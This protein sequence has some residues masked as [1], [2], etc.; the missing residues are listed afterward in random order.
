MGVELPNSNFGIIECYLE[1][2]EYKMATRFLQKV[3]Q[4]NYSSQS[5]IDFAVR[6]HSQGF[7]KLSEEIFI[8]FLDDEDEAVSLVATVSL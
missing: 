6:L 5:Y 8:E 2:D 4:A 7:I 1:L 3:I